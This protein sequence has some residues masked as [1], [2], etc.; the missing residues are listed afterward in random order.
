M[1]SRPVLLQL[2][3][4][5]GIDYVDLTP[6]DMTTEI[7]KALDKKFTKTTTYLK[8][9][10]GCSKELIKFA[11]EEYDYVLQDRKGNIVNAKSNS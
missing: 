5:L 2:C 9:I 7:R 10:K 8:S 6:E 4:E 1:A 3:K 11:T